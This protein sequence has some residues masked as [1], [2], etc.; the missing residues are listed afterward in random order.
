MVRVPVRVSLLTLVAVAVLAGSCGGSVD[1]SASVP[2]LRV[3]DTDAATYD[4]D[5]VIPFGT[6]SRM[7]S[8]E[9]VD[10]VPGELNARVGESI[11]IVNEDERGA[12]VGIF[13]VPA[14]R[15]VAMEFTTP[16][17]LTGQCDVHPSGEFTINVTDA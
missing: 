5:Y 2:D 9:E 10:I 4:Y 1:D 6:G 14:E 16:G 12:A 13:W 17:T 7:D 11:R 3:L 8:G 15:T